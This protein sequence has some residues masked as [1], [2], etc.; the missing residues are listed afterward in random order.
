MHYR[1][2]AA[3]ICF[4]FNIVLETGIIP[5]SW[6]EGIIRPIYK[7]SGTPRNAEIY[8]PITN[9]SCL[10][11][12]F[13]AVLNLRLNNFLKHNDI[14]EENQAVFRAGYS[15]TDHIFI[16]HTLTEILKVNKKLYCSF[17]DFSKPF[18]SVW[19][20]GLWMKL[21]KEGVDGKFFFFK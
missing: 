15:T 12:L 10:G 20:V 21:L 19:R 18:D 16:L 17:I 9:L 3:Y 11:K 5:D 7:N 6:I 2:Y 8:R 4:L 14:L 13:T 1:H